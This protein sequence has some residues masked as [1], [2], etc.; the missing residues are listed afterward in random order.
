MVINLTPDIEPVLY[1]LAEKQGTTIEL[2][3]LKMLRQHLLINKPIQKPSI[4][5]RNAK[6]LADFLDGHVGVIDSSEFV[7]GSAQMSKQKT[8]KWPKSCLKNNDKENYD[9][10]RHWASNCAT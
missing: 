5:R 7:K 10:Y 3:V 4:N 1:E 9:T 2:L 8:S 6:T